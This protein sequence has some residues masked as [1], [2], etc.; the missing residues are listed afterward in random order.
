VPATLGNDAG[1]IGAAAL[2]AEAV[3]ADRMGDQVVSTA[4]SGHHGGSNA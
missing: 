1:L 2:A 3:G 4:D